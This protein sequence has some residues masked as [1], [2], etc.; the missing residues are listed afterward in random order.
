M[1]SEYASGKSDVDELFIK[2]AEKLALWLD[3]ELV[4]VSLEEV[5]E[6]TK[7]VKTDK[8]FFSH[9]AKVRATLEAL[10]IIGIYLTMACRPS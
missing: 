2:T 1:I 6:R 4:N 9:Y 3:T 7:P 8:S 5:W 10:R